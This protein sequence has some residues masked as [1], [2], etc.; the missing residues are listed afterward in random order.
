[1]DMSPVLVCYPDGVGMNPEGSG[2]RLDFDIMGCCSGEGEEGL[3]LPPACQFITKGPPH[4]S[5][6]PAGACW[7]GLHATLLPFAGIA[8]V[9]SRYRACAKAVKQYGYSDAAFAVSPF[10]QR[11]PAA[12]VCL[13]VM[14]SASFSASFHNGQ[15]FLRMCVLISSTRRRH[16]VRLYRLR[17][18]KRTIYRI[19]LPCVCASASVHRSSCLFAAA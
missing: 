1:L 19:S 4:G 6:R 5:R 16:S 13:M 17:R 12:A 9:Y 14:V 7:R 10:R 11:S 2:Q 3:R 8:D 15:H 18:R